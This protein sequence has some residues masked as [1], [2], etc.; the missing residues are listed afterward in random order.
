[1]VKWDYSIRQGDVTSRV[2][3]I[4]KKYFEIFLN[5]FPS[6]VI[7]LVKFDP[8]VNIK[9]NYEK[10]PKMTTKKYFFENSEASFVHQISV[11]Y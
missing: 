3:R 5:F 10:K 11:F 2:D 7:F 4:I 8:K 6:A 9:V 1:M